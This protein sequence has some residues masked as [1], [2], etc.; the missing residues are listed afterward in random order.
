LNWEGA[1]GPWIIDFLNNYLTA[2]LPTGIWTDGAFVF[3]TGLDQ[4]LRCW[5]LGGIVNLC[6]S[7]ASSC[8]M[9]D[10]S[11]TRLLSLPLVE[12][13]HCVID[14]PEAEDLHVESGPMG[15]CSNR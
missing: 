3:S 1:L 10:P 12:C 15:Y 11:D 4:R 6:E 8:A 5:H 9:E 7:P 13:G 2:T 14:V